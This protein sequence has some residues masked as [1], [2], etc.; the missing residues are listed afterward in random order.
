M[1]FQNIEYFL[2]VVEYRNFTK[3]AQSL[4]ISQQSLSENIRRLEEEIGTPLLY[5][6]RSLSLTP[7][8]EF[9]VSG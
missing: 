6:C 3:A 2:A 5:R 7:A 8:G 9:L 1:N 4:Y